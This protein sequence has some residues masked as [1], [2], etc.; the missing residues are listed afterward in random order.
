[1][2]M[3]TT[4]LKRNIDLVLAEWK[5]E[6]RRKTLLLRGA[7]QVGKS[8]AVRNLSKSFQ[9]FIEV[10]FD[11]EKTV[12]RFFEEDN[13]PQEI[14]QQLA[15]YYRTPI[16]AGETLLFFDEIQ[17]CL[18]ALTKLR[19]FYEKLPEIHLIA[20]G[21]LLE[22]ALGEIASFG[23]GRIRSVFMYPFSFDEFLNALGDGMLVDAYRKATPQMPL[24]D[25]IHKQ[26]VKRLKLFLIIGGMP[27]AVS[28]YVLSGDL[29]RSQL[30]LNDLLVTYQ[31]DFSK[32]RKRIPDSRIREVFESVAHQVEG[33]FIFEK[34]ANGCSHAQIKQA[35]DLLIM[36]GLVYPVTHSSS[37]GIPLGAEMDMKYRRM[38]LLDT[39]LL[40]Q[41]LG[42]DVSQLFLTDDFKVINNGALAE[43]FVG[44][45][46]VKNASFYKPAQLYCWHRENRKC[47]AQVD[48]VIQQGEL[49]VPV[50]VK[51]GTRGSM[52]SLRIFMDEKNSKKGIRTS[53]E[54]FGRFDNIEIYPLYA[55]SNVIR[56]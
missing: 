51:S 16:V 13:T 34:A 22:F 21:S 30:V 10:N 45:E 50:E 38:F 7:R 17:A 31:N 33:K 19:Y 47:N 23:V 25:P 40:Q 6:K 36:A 29:L 1:M 55:I 11:D 3:E 8:F 26:L 27:E 53:L 32:Y 14:C 12:R 35:L 37:N 18:P 39:G 48:F 9:Y 54:N 41:I 15:L 5:E 4:Y 49:I 28:E 24:S 42:L 56:Q 43:L 20:A 46:L 44:L 52:Q 2:E